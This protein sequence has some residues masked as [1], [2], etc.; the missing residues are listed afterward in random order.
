MNELKPCFVATA[1]LVSLVACKDGDL[2]PRRTF[3][4]GTTSGAAGTPSAPSGVDDPLNPLTADQKA[5]VE[6]C[7]AKQ[8][9]YVGLGGEKL[10]AGR[11]ETPAGFDHARVKPYAVLA[12]ELQRTIGYVPPALAEAKD[13]FGEAP[14][15]WYEEPELGSIALFQAYRLAFD[16][17]TAYTAD[18]ARFAADPTRATAETECRSMQRSFWSRA[19]SPE[20]LESCVTV[21]LSSS[22]EI[23]PGAGSPTQVGPRRRWAYACASVLSSSRFLTY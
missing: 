2:L 7:K 12:S 15:R 22:Q 4:D 9:S 11:F 16:G 13:V 3:G 18:D 21:A 14:A 20:E 6:A 23:A 17:C 10:E 5:E 19:P 8:R 1:A